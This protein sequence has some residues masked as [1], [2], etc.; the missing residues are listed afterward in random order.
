MAIRAP[1]GA[2]NFKVTKPLDLLQVKGNLDA[3]ATVQAAWLWW[4][5]TGHNVQRSK[6]VFDNNVFQHRSADKASF[7][8]T[9]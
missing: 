7:S 5:G 2:N 9:G 1:D 6:P 3:C 4:V 8:T